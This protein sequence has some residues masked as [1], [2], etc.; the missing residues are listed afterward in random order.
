MVNKLRFQPK[1]RQSALLPIPDI[2]ET[3]CRW[4]GALVSH[5][6]PEKGATQLKR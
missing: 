6:V 1:S 2:P 4:E 5:P 3:R